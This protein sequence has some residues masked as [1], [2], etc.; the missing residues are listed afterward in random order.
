MDPEAQA[1]AQGLVSFVQSL[2]TRSKPDWP[3]VFRL[4]SFD[5]AGQLSDTIDDWEQIQ[6]IITLSLR[7][8]TGDDGVRIDYSGPTNLRPRE[9]TRLWQS[10]PSN[11]KLFDVVNLSEP[12]DNL[13]SFLPLDRQNRTVID[14]DIEYNGR[15]FLI[16]V[17]VGE[18]EIYPRAADPEFGEDVMINVRLMFTNASEEDGGT[19][20]DGSRTKSLGLTPDD[21]TLA[22]T[23]VGA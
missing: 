19:L 5:A 9:I 23:E 14:A 15:V 22:T 2:L 1:Q 7:N 20:S 18:G 12:K 17:V 8:Y 6:G 10:R 11:L 21:Y 3:T 16:C 13:T 4:Q